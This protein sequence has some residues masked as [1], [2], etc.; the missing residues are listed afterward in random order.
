MDEW[1]S[2]LRN[3]YRKLFIFLSSKYFCA[4]IFHILCE[5]SCRRVKGFS[6]QT[7][8]SKLFRCSFGCH[9]SFVLLCYNIKIAGKLRRIKVR[10][11]RNTSFIVFLF[12]CTSSISTIIVCLAIS[13]SISKRRWSWVIRRTWTIWVL[14]TVIH[15]PHIPFLCEANRIVNNGSFQYLL[16]KTTIVMYHSCIKHKLISSILFFAER[17]PRRGLNE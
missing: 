1:S 8:V 2:W 15:L 17:G 7:A 9:K 14:K 10:K 3:I 12:S 4:S 13:S 5:I 6:Q 16:G 11:Y